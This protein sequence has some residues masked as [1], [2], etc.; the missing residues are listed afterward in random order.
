LLQ[1]TA[2]NPSQQNR[3]RLLRRNL[4]DLFA[5]MSQSISA[6]S[7][8]HSPAS[9]A[10]DLA[11][12]KQ[13]M[14][15]MR[16][17]LNAM[18]DE[19]GRLLVQRELAS[20]AS[21]GR[22]VGTF[23]IATAIAVLLVVG[24][25]L[26]I[27]RD[28]KLRL[29]NAR[30]QNRLANYNRLLIES[31]GEGIYGVDLSGK[32]T[33]LNAAG[34]RVLKLDPIKV[35]GL[36]MHTVTHHTRAD[37]S[38]YPV[39]QCQIYNT[40]RTGKGCRVDDEVLW[41][42]DGT[43]FPAEY[44][45]YP[46][47]NDDLI[48]GV[49]V[50]FAD[51]TARKKGE[52]DLKR[53]RDEAE[54]AKADAE[55][56]NVAKSQF[57]A[58]MS[59]ELRTPLNAVIMYSELLQE[60]ATD[61]GVESFIPDLDKIRSGGKHL[62]ALV[63][64]VLD[65]SKIEAGKMD[66]FL[67]TFDV[68]SMVRDVTSTV[69]ALIQKKSNKLRVICSPDV[70]EMHA[71][72]TKVRQILFNLLSNAAKF[73]ENGTIEIEVKREEHPKEQPEKSNGNNMILFRVRDTGIGMT[74]AQINKLFQPFMQADDSTTR[75]FGGTGLGLA[76]TQS[77]CQMMG[78][79]VSVTSESGRGSTFSIH[80]PARVARPE[81]AASTSTAAATV[82]PLKRGAS[83]VLI[84]DDE[85]S[86][87][88]LMSRALSS[89][90]IY[91]VTAS[92]GEDGLRQ[93]HELKPDLI[94]LDVMMPKMD[95]WAVLAAL[96]ADPALA[97]IPV[98][99]LTIVGDREMG[100]TLGASEYLSKPID[101]ALLAKM[102]EKYCMKSS[103]RGVMIV[104]DD[105]A[106][107]QVV[108]RTLTRAGWTVVDAENGRVALERLKKFEPNLIL[109]DL[110]MPQMDGFEF[111]AALRTDGVHANVPVVV[112]TSKDLTPSER[113]QLTGRVE[114]IVQKGDYSREA[115]LRE[116]KQLVALTESGKAAS[117]RQSVDSTINRAANLPGNE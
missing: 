109:L 104:D 2:D 67:E 70:G 84:I 98:V 116:I 108:S 28:E 57:L 47:R 22:A 44:S 64:G 66:L 91:A 105:D 90:D 97:S 113:S 35:I 8:P 21:L 76:I 86:V 45:A 69:E 9:A 25:F 96:K 83:T 93:A 10:E 46:I 72:L 41:R 115:L 16:Q 49:V 50:A 34:A 33:F 89:Q 85:P 39:E 79:D 19:E 63:N 51:I 12:G 26:L 52:E 102:V 7:A 43:S 106:T 80:L 32:C 99:M 55:A 54:A 48:D 71:D 1:L 94:F 31:T 4:D 17:N 36:N 100:Y 112:L 14:D 6:A 29:R 110:V 77:F 103:T 107:R 111:L 68:P 42:S 78:G 5:N 92:N 117:T 58:N 24:A 95:G 73:T 88:D 75:K 65:L 62:L 74:P 38:P 81:G 30:E 11:D 20:K 61:R 87:R 101:R 3:L 60:E 56:A 37:G 27:R 59:H 82:G 13:T 114:K 15:D 23:V 53:A 18:R 40:L